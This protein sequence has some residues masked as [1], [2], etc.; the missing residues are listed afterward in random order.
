MDMT[1]KIAFG[2][3]FIW[4]VTIAV[5]LKIHLETKDNN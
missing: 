1:D 2:I 5:L 3:V 4:F